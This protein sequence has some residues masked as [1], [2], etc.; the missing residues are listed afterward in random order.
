MKIQ[1]IRC[2]RLIHDCSVHTPCRKRS[3]PF[4][5]TTLSFHPHI[6]YQIPIGN[7]QTAYAQCSRYEIPFVIFLKHTA[8]DRF[9][10][11]NKTIMETGIDPH[12]HILLYETQISFDKLI[13]IQADLRFEI[14]TEEIIDVPY[15]LYPRIESRLELML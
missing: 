15:S 7:Q 13:T 10:I 14:Q 1:L 6:L 9:G 4:S 5:D 2:F 11:R 12:H 8:I 3:I